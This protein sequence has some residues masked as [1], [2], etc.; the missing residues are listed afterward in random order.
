[1]LAVLTCWL[2]LLSGYHLTETILNATTIFTIALARRPH[3][4]CDSHRYRE[5]KREPPQR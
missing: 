1:M 5:V 4:H 2:S 3:M